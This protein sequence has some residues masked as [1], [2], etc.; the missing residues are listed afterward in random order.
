MQVARSAQKA[1]GIELKNYGFSSTDANYPVSVG[2][3]ATCLCA[4]GQQVDNHTTAEYYVKEDIHLGPQ[5]VF[6]TA[7]ALAGFEQ[8]KPLLPKRS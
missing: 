7:V 3:P 1:L 8:F 5:L 2:I 4:G 6:L